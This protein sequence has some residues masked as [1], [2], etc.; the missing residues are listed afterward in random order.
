MLFP[1]L[2]TVTKVVLT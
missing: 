2:E 1:F